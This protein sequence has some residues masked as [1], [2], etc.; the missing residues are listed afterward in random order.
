MITL[1]IRNGDEIALLSF[2]PNKRIAVF[3]QFIRFLQ[4]LCKWGI[5]LMKETE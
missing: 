4:Q 5:L 1:E 3:S 2:L